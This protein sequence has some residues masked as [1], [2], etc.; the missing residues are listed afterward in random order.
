MSGI[1]VSQKLSE[2]TKNIVKLKSIFRVANEKIR[3]QIEA[4]EENCFEEDFEESMLW[5]RFLFFGFGINFY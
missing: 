3:K 2:Q 4:L 1:G 5:F